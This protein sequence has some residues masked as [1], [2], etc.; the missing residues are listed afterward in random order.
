MQQVPRGL[1]ER[2]K[3]VEITGQG[4]QE[5]DPSPHAGLT[6]PKPQANGTHFGMRQAKHVL[7]HIRFAPLSLPPSLSMVARVP[8]LAT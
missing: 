8:G 7:T 2:T 3:K 4:G 1:E 6:S 5:T